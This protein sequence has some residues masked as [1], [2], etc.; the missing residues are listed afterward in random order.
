MILGTVIAIMWVFNLIFLPIS[1]E[2]LDTKDKK[3]ILHLNSIVAIL[4]ISVFYLNTIY[5]ENGI[6]VSALCASI[7]A[8]NNSISSSGIN[9]IIPFIA[10]KESYTKA[11][12]IATTFNSFQTIIGAFLGG[13]FIAIWG[14]QG[15][16]I[17]VITLYSISYLLVHLIKIKKVTTSERNLKD[18]NLTQ[19]MMIGFKVL[20]KLSAE[21]HI[22]YTSMISNFHY[23]SFINSGY[24]FLYCRKNR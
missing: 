9:S 24:T 14:V 11:I 3:K 2:L 16:I 21:K 23:Y 20:S 8:A 13:G 6:I 12:G 5:L 19:R 1:G 4:A 22:C 15:A 17:I 18:N 7:L 10:K